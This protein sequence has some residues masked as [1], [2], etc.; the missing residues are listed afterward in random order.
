MSS[1]V[2]IVGG[3]VVSQNDRIGV[4]AGGEVAFDRVTGTIGYVGAARG[5]AGAGDVDAREHVVM[6]GLVNAHTHSGMTPLRGVCEDATFAVWLGQVREFEARMTRDDIY[7]ALQLA[8]VEMLRSGTTT[9]AD[10]FLWDSRL[11]ASVAAAG[12]RVLAAPAIFGY[13][14]V[15]YPG[16]SGADGR[17]VIAETERLAAEFAGDRYIRIA[18]GPHAPYTC[19]PELL[20]DVAKRAERL[21]LP[22]HVHLSETT[23]EVRE[24]IARFGRTPVAHA[25]NHGLLDG[26]SLV[27]HCNHPTDADIELL[28]HRGAAVAH[29]PVSNLKLGAGIAPVPR[30]RAAG[31]TVG[32]GTD[33]VASNNTLDLFE[34]IKT[35]VLV[36]RGLHESPDIA[37]GADYLSMATSLGARAVGLPQVGQLVA[38]CWA[39]IV[40]LDAARPHATPMHSAPAYLA[41][42]ARG[43]DV[44]H[45]FVGG[46]QVVADRVVTT[47][48]EVAARARVNQTAARIRSH[49]PVPPS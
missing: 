24:S 9:F 30:L 8:L 15:S 35:G 44:R 22:V 40:I 26:P 20:Q 25:A 21:G 31:V 13:D 42:A 45:V 36:Q 49:Q 10:M 7:W 3:T 17:T 4:V 14:A 46:R 38:G 1:E 37:L 34:E 19:S 6:P 41:F 18:F 39:D 23:H 33:S 29:N 5:P 28:A 32:L 16:A 12:M 43:A 11:L 47:V 27:A 48:D 2:R